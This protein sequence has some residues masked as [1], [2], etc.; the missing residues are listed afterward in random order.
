MITLTEEAKELFLNVE[1]PEGEILRLDPVTDE[2]TGETGIGISV[3]EPRGD[4]QVVKHYGEDLL[5]IDA[6]VSEALD[7]SILNLVE[8]PEGTGIGITTPERGPST[9]GSST[10]DS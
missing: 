4:D 2:S 7:G 8:T 9:N 3:G 5:H 10:D 1:R 6:S